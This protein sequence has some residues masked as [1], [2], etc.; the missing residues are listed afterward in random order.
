MIRARD[1]LV[2]ETGSGGDLQIDGSDLKGAF[3][4]ENF[5]YLAMFGGNPESITEET[6]EGQ[7]N[8]DF[9]GN[10]VLWSGNPEIQF[11]SRTEK[12]LR[13]VAL[14]SSGR[15]TIEEAVK[16]DLEFMQ[17]FSEVSVVV[18]LPGLDRV[19]IGILIKEPNNGVERRFM[20][21]WDGAQL[22]GEKADPVNKPKTL[23]SG[24]EENLQFELG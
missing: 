6:T 7:E 13:E 23:G 10:S 20:Y 8:F 5:P 22:I 16:A 21:I 2:I 11:N 14:N 4:F 3:S 18:T 19:N 24:L 17:A 9:W 1:L 15:K 12:V